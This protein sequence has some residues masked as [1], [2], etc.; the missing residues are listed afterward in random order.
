MTVAGFEC[1]V[2]VLAQRRNPPPSHYLASGAP[3]SCA[4][5]GAPFR[6]HDGLLACWRGAD[7]RYYCS[8]DC[9]AAGRGDKRA[10]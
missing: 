3:T 10:A 1:G 8:E 9:S 2:Y 5:C 4:G 6:V 7:R